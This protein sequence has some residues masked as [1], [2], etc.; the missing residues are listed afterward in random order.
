MSDQR[1]ESIISAKGITVSFGGI[2]VVKSVDIELFPGE[3]HAIAGE[4]GAGKSTLA[5]VIAGVY[6]PRL[7]SLALHGK[8]IKLSNPRDALTKGIG[9]IHQEPH[10]FPELDVAENIFIA[11]HPKS[12]PIVTWS[13]LYSE[14]KRILDSLGIDLDPRAPVGGLSVAHQQMVEL[15]SVMSHDAQV[16]IFDETTAPLTPKESEELFKVMRSLTARGCAVA[17]VTH[18]L[19]DILKVSDRITILRDGDKVAE[20]K[21]AETNV[22]EIVRTMVG[23]QLSLEKPSHSI[24][25][26]TATLQVK[27]LSGPGFHEVSFDIKAGEIVCLAGL[28]GA[29]RTEVANAIFGIT[30]PFKGS[31]AL[32]GN[33]ITKLNPRRAIQSGLAFVPEDRHKHGL[34][35]ALSISLNSTL[36]KLPSLAKLGWIPNAKLNELSL[37][38]ADRMNLAYR[39]LDQSAGEL[40]GGNQQKVVL[41]KWIM[42]EPKVLI[43]DE[44]TRGVDVGAKFEVHNLVREQAAS[45]MSVLLISSDLA[46]VLALSDRI[47]V[48]RGG[49]IVAQFDGKTATQDQIMFAASGQEAVLEA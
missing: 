28:V 46:E 32:N 26:G 44:P 36:A 11:H 27:N 5:K 12:G 19:E 42:T 3:I 30:Q 13:K 16:W 15:A 38:Y 37:Q 41:A 48:M 17:M 2:D 34:F 21:P 47:L 14:A 8:P 7:G 6:Q 18:H 23:R 31:V 49:T 33:E 20:L 25:L 9:L 45:G 43:L 40:S 35:G 1:T 4:N 10:T 22:D 24:S 29:G 39:N